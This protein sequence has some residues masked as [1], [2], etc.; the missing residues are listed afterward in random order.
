[1]KKPLVFFLLVATLVTSLACVTLSSA[2]SNA[3]IPSS[4]ATVNNDEAMANVLSTAQAQSFKQV[5]LGKWFEMHGSWEL[6]KGTYGATDPQR[7]ARNEGYFT[8]TPIPYGPQANGSDAGW[9]GA[10]QPDC[11]THLQLHKA[12]V[13]NSTAQMLRST[14]IEVKAQ[15]GSGA[16]RYSMIFNHETRSSAELMEDYKV[17]ASGGQLGLFIAVQ[18]PAMQPALLK[19]QGKEVLVGYACSHCP[20]HTSGQN[21][22]ILPLVDITTLGPSVPTLGNSLYPGYV[23]PIPSPEKDA[24]FSITDL[25]A[26]IPEGT[27]LYFWYGQYNP[28]K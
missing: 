18:D 28:T 3:P 27:V 26:E 2:P 15:Q 13:S 17:A 1:M 19:Y 23:I 20:A 12:E 9:C 7:K 14:L 22:E 5:A 10:G 8:V 6:V 11:P 24:D 4:T 25:V 21:G 16:F